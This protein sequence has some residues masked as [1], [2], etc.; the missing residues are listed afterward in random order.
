MIIGAGPGGYVCA[1]RAASLGVETIIID[2]AEMGGTCLNRGCIPSKA[3]IHAANEYDKA[4]HNKAIGID[5]SSAK[6][7]F[8]K[9]QS[10]KSGIVKKLQNGVAHLVN[11]AGAKFIAGE[12]EIVDG[13]TVRVRMGETINTIT[14]DH[15]V[16]ATGSVPLELPHFPFGGDCL[17]STTVLEL[18]TLPKSLAVIGGGYIGIELGTAMA[19]LGVK[20]SIIELGAQ[21]LPQYDK[22]LTAPVVT[23]LKALGVEIHL[24]AK[25]ESFEN[26]TLS[27]IEN[28]EAKTLLSEKLLVTIGRKAQTD[29]AGIN[30]LDLKK[31]GELIAVDAR[32]QTSM[33][34]VYAIGDIT[35]GPQLAHRAMA[36]GK[37]IAE[38]VAG[39]N[40]AW[41]KQA[42]PAICF[43]DP[44]IVSVGITA[45]EMA[46]ET[47]K[48]TEFPLSANGRSLALNAGAGF[49]RVIYDAKSHVISGLEAVGVEVSELS[50]QFS[51][52]IEMGARLED[53]ADTIHAHPTIGEATQEAALFALGEAIHF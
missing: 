20:T 33:R 34:A 53:L 22:K 16:L 37:L 17:S 27:Y 49:V 40:Q 18:E 36:Q 7:D 31:D 3:L 9:T 15:L 26:G 46:P 10:W 43:S 1:I 32:C 45:R 23:R 14:C 8:A 52:A 12:A 39:Q 29:G 6:I 13:K 5:V 2:K 42:I 50:G 41:D 47:M 24:N 25:A 4:T 11:A 51:L 19:K 21:I 30:S 38:I 35:P 48:L 44:E 28:G